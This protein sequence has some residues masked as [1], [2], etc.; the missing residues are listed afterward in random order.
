LLTSKATEVHCYFH[1][2][3]LKLPT[4]SKATT[5][6]QRRNKMRLP[7][8]A[9]PPL[10]TKPAEEEIIQRV[11][12]RRGSLGL[13]AVDRTLL[14][15]PAIT[16]GWHSFFGAINTSTSLRIDLRKIAICRVA[17]LN[18]ARYQ[19]DGHAAALQTCEGFNEEMM[20]V[21]KTRQPIDRGPLS[22]EQWAVLRYADAM[23]KNVVI[24][25]VV[26][27]AVKQAGFNSEE[28]VELTATIAAYN[29]V[30]RF[31]VAL[32]VGE[33]NSVSWWVLPNLSKSRWWVSINGLPI[34]THKL[35]QCRGLWW[36]LSSLDRTSV[37]SCVVSIC[38]LVNPWI[39]QICWGIGGDLGQRQLFLDGILRDKNSIKDTS[40]SNVSLQ[41]S[42]FSLHQRIAP[43][44]NMSD[45][46]QQSVQE[47]NKQIVARYSEEFWGKCNPDIV[48]E[49]C[50]DDFL[51][52][53]PMH[54]P[55]RGKEAAKQMLI[56]F[57]EVILSIKVGE[58]TLTISGIS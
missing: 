4:T 45:T 31:L 8:I 35:I 55:R 17:L 53:Y 12:A 24:D 48:D 49:L 43:T 56:E 9:N 36:F 23:T 51:S 52:N 22:L 29:C 14:H 54:G 46:P 57:K 37:A 20:N 38:Q 40:I 30:S 13:L 28:I 47:K 15:S 5:S 27:D 6:A 33:R 3:G 16:D 11:L 10:E 50:S 21:V 41:N 58:P 18:G 7:Y 39:S 2:I 1:S 42:T 34:L 26:F 32:D 44:V 19:W 25:D